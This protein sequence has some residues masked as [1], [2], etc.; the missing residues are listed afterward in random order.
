MF[1][2]H[3]LYGITTGK[4]DWAIHVINLC[5]VVISWGLVTTEV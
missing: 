5:H 3:V 4:G 2:G 1:N